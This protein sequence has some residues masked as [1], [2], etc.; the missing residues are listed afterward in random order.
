MNSI[1]NENIALFKKRF[2]ELQK[3]IRAEISPEI[4]LETAKNGSV[5][6]SENSVMLHSK[7]NPQKEAENLT[8]Q[9]D[10]EKKDAA[11]FL[12]FGLGYAPVSFAKKNKNAAMILVEPDEKRFFSA[13]N[14]LDW[15]EIFLHEKL[16]LAVGASAEDLAGIISSY[17]AEKIFVFKTKAQISH[18]EEFFSSVEKII[19]QN[20]SR[21]EINENTLEKFSVLWLNNSCRNLDEMKNR[22][23]VKK[24]ASTSCDIPFV[25]LAAGPSLQ[26]FK[27]VLPEIKK[28]AILICVDTAL[29]FCLRENVEPDFIILSDPQ[30]YCSMHLQ[31]LSSPS[32]ILVTEIGVYPSVFRFCCK[33]KILFSS[34]FPIGKFFESRTEKKGSLAAGGSVATTAW[35][36]AR[37]CGAKEIFFGG[38]D[39]GFPKKQT[40]IRGSRFEEKCHAESFRL[41]NAETE[42]AFSLFCA[43]AFFAE[44]YDGKKILTDKRMALFSWWFETQC[45]KAK[46]DGCK[47]FSLTWESMKIKNVEKFPLE[48][49]LKKDEMEIQKKIFF[50]RAEE[51]NRSENFGAEFDEA[52][53]NFSRDLEKLSA[54]A[55]RGINLCQRGIQN[56]ACMADVCKKLNEIDREISSSECKDSASLVFP[57]E[58]QLEKLSQKISCANEN[59]KSIYPLKFS[60]LIYSELLKSVE[61]FKKFF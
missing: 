48:E 50:I 38:M 53:K 33:E 57:T 43:D 55:E 51:K 49:F 11:I 16:I 58:R 30:F 21:E 47:T 29:H 26:N 5:T 46:A 40:H 17:R 18:A 3:K 42:N 22:G 6:A 34:L 1:W 24:F 44:D 13:L 20:K 25:I 36:F 32:S 59:E 10:G 12:G 7:Y 61:R 8:A 4:I 2:P 14:A 37:L 15:T 28:R 41:K 52:K 31:F 60:A 39:L 56:R 35:D 54:L 9:F 19:S 45:G 23:G 27:N